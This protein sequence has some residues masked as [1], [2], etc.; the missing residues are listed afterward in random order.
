MTT[1]APPCVHHERIESPHGTETV[2]SVC[3]LCGQEREYR[4]AHGHQ[5]NN[6]PLNDPRTTSLGRKLKRNW[7]EP[8]EWQEKV[9]G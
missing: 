8:L 4:T 2:K 7:D 5:Y 6:D 1:E 9:W 3:K